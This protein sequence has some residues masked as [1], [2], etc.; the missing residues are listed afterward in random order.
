M[1]GRTLFRY[2]LGDMLRALI[3]ALAWLMTVGL[4]AVWVRARFT[5]VGRVL[6][7]GDCLALMPFVVP[8][9]FSIVLPPAMLAASCSSFGRL[10]AENELV[11]MRAAGL[12]WRSMATVPLALGLVGS[13]TL[14]WL[15]LEGFRYAGAAMAS[16][17]KGNEIDVNRLCSPGSVL[18]L[19]SGGRRLTFSFL[20]PEE[21][22]P[23]PVHVT[24]TEM[25]GGRGL[26]LSARNF[27][28]VPRTED[29]EGDRPR[30]YVTFVLRNVNVVTDA[31][32]P[33]DKEEFAEYRLPEM[34]L[35]SGMSRGLLGNKNMTLSLDQNL[36]AARR[37]RREIDAGVAAFPALVSQARAR[38]LAAAARGGDPDAVCEALRV[39]EGERRKVA[40]RIE[41]LHEVMAEAARKL[42]F[43][44]SPLVFAF[45][46][47]GMGAA[48]RKSSKLVSLSL[49]VAAAAAYYGAWVGG[50]AFA[51]Y[52][53][54][55]PSLAPWLP[56]VLGLIGG[57]IIVHRQNRS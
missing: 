45:L 49:G 22:S 37:L 8:Y 31:F 27:D 21:G 47:L 7:L 53:V 28:A 13:L 23:R 30:R 4:L 40:S 29:R 38:A 15:N 46:G 50:R 55:S 3:L 24:S 32:E 34:E 41:D 16:R 6:G 57:W 12:S 36:A 17:E 19:D 20:N 10:A 54:V 56:N 35:P 43:S 39:L 33:L 1:I 2:V 44:F 9:L 26:Q 51:D 52:G 5:S 42:A 48:A 25:E 11:A 18:P 14:L